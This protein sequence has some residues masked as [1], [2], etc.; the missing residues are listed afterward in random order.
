MDKKRTSMES[1]ELET[2]VGFF[3]SR[4]DIYDD[5]HSRPDITWGIRSREITAEK[6]SKDA[7]HILDLGCGTGLELE[8]I[9]KAN[10]NIE[11]TCIDISS[12]MLEVLKSKYRDKKITVVCGDYFKC[13]FGVNVFDNV[14]SVMSLHH[15]TSEEKSLLYKKIYDSLKC[16]GSFINCDYIVDTLLEEKSHLQELEKIRS[17]IDVST[18]LYHIDIPLCEKNEVEVLLKSGFSNI[19]KAWEN[20]KTKLLISQK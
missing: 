7:K 17:K 9:F 4:A 6:I 19:V 14:I 11:V 16:G 12:K 10:P 2:M 20:K 13:D 8:G 1:D 3:D 5:I 18:N 15:F